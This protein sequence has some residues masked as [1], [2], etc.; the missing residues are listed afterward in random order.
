MED[1]EPIDFIMT[2]TLYFKP[3]ELLK[4]RYRLFDNPE[5]DKNPDLIKNHESSLMRWLLSD[6]TARTYLFSKLKVEGV[7]RALADVKHPVI[8]QPLPNSYRPG[9]ID[10]LLVLDE[11][12]RSIAIEAKVVKVTVSKEEGEKVNARTVIHKGI[13]QANGLRIRYG[14]Y[15]SY[16][17]ILVKVDAVESEEGSLFHKG[18][19]ESS[20]RTIVEMFGSS[21]DLHDDVGLIIAELVQPTTK[22][23]QSLNRFSIPYIELATPTSQEY[24]LT[25]RIRE[26]HDKPKAMQASLVWQP[27]VRGE[28]E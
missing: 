9:D 6:D 3:G 25:N 20:W 14:F 16:L 2:D 11:G 17:L 12:F 19:S 8:P 5:G 22:S 13:I 24:E 26:L 15:Q 4:E 18:A 23:F 7:L 21:S 28:T 27:E 10:A 1:D